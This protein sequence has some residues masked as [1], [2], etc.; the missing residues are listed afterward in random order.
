MSKAQEILYSKLTYGK[1]THIGKEE[2]ILAAIKEIASLSYAAGMECAFRN[3][4]LV[5]KGS[6]T[7]VKKNFAQVMKDK[8]DYLA[9]L[10]GE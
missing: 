2:N 5:Q 3:T 6:N 1:N 10:F 8:N 9:K 4:T 7:G